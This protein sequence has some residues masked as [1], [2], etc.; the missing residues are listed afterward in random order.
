MYT[1][2]SRVGGVGMLES[3]VRFQKDL[4]TLSIQ[5]NVPLNT[6]ELFVST[7]KCS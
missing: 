5:K 4:R 2:G 3:R 7:K 1:L 6:Y